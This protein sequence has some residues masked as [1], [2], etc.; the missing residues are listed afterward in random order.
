MIPRLFNRTCFLW[1]GAILI[2]LL[3]AKPRVALY[4]RLDTMNRAYIDAILKENCKDRTAISEAREYYEILV[5][6]YPKYGR[7]LEMAGACRLL[8]KQDN[9]ALKDFQQAVQNNSNLFWVSFEIGKIFYR[10]GEYA[11]ALEYFEAIMSQDKNIL[12]KKAVLSNLRGLSNNTRKALMLTLINFVADI[13][14]QSYHLAIGCMGH[15]G[16]KVL[17]KEMVSWIDAAANDQPVFHPWSYVISP[18]KEITYQ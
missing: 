7:G 2:V 13:K 6:L 8:L 18:L 11:V 1:A 4:Q 16:D 15:L 5:E 12:F 17:R 3:I 10:R 14:E 9:L